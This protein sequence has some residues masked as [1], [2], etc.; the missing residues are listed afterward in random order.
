[1]STYGTILLIM[2]LYADMWNNTAYFETICRHMESD[3]AVLTVCRHMESDC[4]LRTICQNM[5]QY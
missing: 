3:C 5:E 1:M 2:K 4:M